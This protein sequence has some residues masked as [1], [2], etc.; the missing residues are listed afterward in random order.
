MKFLCEVDT[1]FFLDA[2]K[3]RLEEENE[4]NRHSDNAYDILFSDEG[5]VSVCVWQNH[6]KLVVANITY[7]V[8]EGHTQVSLAWET[9]MRETP[10][11]IGAAVAARATV[12]LVKGAILWGAVYGISYPFGNR[13]LLLPL[14][15]PV[16]VWAVPVTG[17]IIRRVGAK[18][19]FVK[20]ITDMLGVT[21]EE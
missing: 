21:P 13:N 5:Q 3:S 11:P 16:C 10:L 20:L 17:A 2:L 4:Q 7:E 12:E 19:R 15:A 8:V 18:D 1:A 6:K 14:I 9:K